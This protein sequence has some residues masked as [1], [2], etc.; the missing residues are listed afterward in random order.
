MNGGFAHVVTHGLPELDAPALEARGAA[1]S[2]A[3]T[4]STA[5]IFVVALNLR[6][7]VTS[8]GVALPDIS[9]AGSLVAA[10]LVALPLRPRPGRPTSEPDRRCRKSEMPWSAQELTTRR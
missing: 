1:L 9:V 2:R 7:A 8:L 4:V 10:V 3:C 5:V 6:P